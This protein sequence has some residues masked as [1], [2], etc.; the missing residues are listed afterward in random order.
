ME[1]LPF[2]SIIFLSSKTCEVLLKLNTLMHKE[3]GNNT[4]K[5]VLLYFETS[6]QLLYAKLSF[7]KLQIY[8]VMG[9]KLN[10]EKQ[11]KLDW[12]Q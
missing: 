9:I 8:V 11:Q 3:T 1:R 6:I 7:A 12:N 10:G 5:H 2:Q 4:I